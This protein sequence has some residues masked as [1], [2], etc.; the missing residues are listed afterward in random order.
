[1]T[2]HPPSTGSLARKSRRP[3]LH[4]IEP[5]TRLPRVAFVICEAGGGHKSAG[6]ALTEALSHHY[7]DSY[8]IVTV[9]IEDMI[10]PVGKAFGTIYDESYNLALQGGHY[11]LE[12]VI[13]GL[14]TK[15]RTTLQPFGIMYMRKA[16]KNLQADFLVFLLHGAH[17]AMAECMKRD[18]HISNL[19]VIT[20]AVSIRPSW[21]NACCDQVVVS[22]PE[23]RQAVEALGVKPEQIELIGHPLDLGFSQPPK[24]R[25][26]LRRR[27]FLQQ[28]RF[29]IMM[30]MGGTGGRN[31]YRF[32]KALINA[33][34]PVQILA[35]CGSDKR[36]LHK[37][38]ALAESSP[39]PI[40]PFGF[41]TEI[42]NLMAVSDLLITKPG[43]G[44][45]MEAM[46][47]ELPMVIDDS[48]YTMWQEKGNVEYVRN[49]NLGRVIGH[50]R[51]FIPAVRELLDHPEQLAASKEAVR[52]HKCVDASAKIAQ[53][54]HERISGK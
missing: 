54:I 16:L 38:Q 49:N 43:P 24:N 28:D 53:L 17:D 23:A 36:L 6:R 22:T 52:Q 3:D 47:M 32:S 4:L 33:G 34:L 1:M 30:M 31:I 40:K 19:T 9:A 50:T 26:E 48:N 42:A 21:V 5:A 14:L 20:D 44:T 45:I 46:A 25:S 29:T 11:W 15:S 37:M 35:C 27:Y 8:D 18:G 10:G 12:P 41:T 13:F 51:E 2:N 39:L 7:P